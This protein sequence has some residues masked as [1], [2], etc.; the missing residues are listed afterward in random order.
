MKS[1][2]ALAGAL[3]IALGGTAS[4]QDAPP[5][6]A[7]PAEAAPTPAPAPA[8]TAPLGRQLSPEETAVL[9]EIEKDFSRWETAA[10]AHGKRVRHI[11]Y[12]EYEDRKL[13]LQRRYGEKITAADAEQRKRRLDAIALL[14]KFI[15]D[16]PSHPQFTPDAM[17]RLASLYLDKANDD[18]QQKFEAEAL[19]Q[20]GSDAPI[21]E[22]DDDSL[23]ADYTKS[24][25]LWTTIVR[26]FP[27]YR[28]RA[29][30]LHLLAYYLQQIGRER[31]GLQVARALVCGNKYKPLDPPPPAPSREAVRAAVAA[32]VKATFTD[33][34]DGCTAISED[35]GLVANTW[36]RIVGNIH[37]FTPGELN[38]AV[39]AYK[40]VA[41]DQKSDYF[42][43]A[44][45]M[46]AWSYYRNDDFIEGIR[47]FDTLV[48]V[49]DELVK[50]D[51]DPQ[52]R[53]ESLQYIAISFTDPWSVTEQPDP[54]RAFER[55][56]SFYKD[57]FN[58]PHVR[59]VFI[60]LGDTFE[61]IEAREQAIDA[62]RIVIEKWPLHPNTPII[63]Q[64]IVAMYEAM[65]DRDM[66]DE[67]A[68][69]LASR[70]APGSEW[71]KAN[72]TDR[73]AMET[74]ARISERMLQA[75]A[76]NTHR[77]AQQARQEYLANQTPEN[78]ARYIE[79]YD[80]AAEL[81]GIF[82]R[83]HPTAP[84]IYEFT[85]RLGE[86][87]FFAEKY[88]QAIEHYKWVR[89]HRELSQERFEAAA[90]S[91]VQTYAKF[92]EQE[93]AAG[94]LVDPPAPELSALKA[95]PKP[96]QPLP[97]P[98]VYQAYRSALDEYM[99]LVNDPKTA[100]DMGY[101]AAVISFKHLDL[102]DAEARFQATLDRHC[103]STEATKAKDG[104]LA[105]YE[106]LNQDDKFRATNEKFISKKCGSEEDMTLARAQNRSKE[107]REAEDLSAAS[108]FDQAAIAFY[109]YY[110]K[111]PAGDPNIPVALYNA[112]LNYDKSGK[113]KT[114]VYLYKEFLAQKDKA[115]TESEYYL[116][117]LYL[118]A[119]SYNNA[120]DY[121]N[122]VKTYLQVVKA[123][124]EKGR[125]PPEGVK[126][127]LQEMQVNAL[128]NA[129]LI[130]ELD[131]VFQD[132]KSDP[133]TGAI[134]L[135]R[136]YIKAETDRRK[137][138]RAQWAIARVY[139][140]AGDLKNLE[141]AYGEWRNEYKN[142]PGNADDYV[143]T[144]YNMAK[145]YE[146]KGKKR[147]AEEK[148]KATIAAWSAVGKPAGGAAGTM[149]AEFDFR[150]AE[151]FKL[152]FDKYKITKTPTTEKEAR[153]VLDTL[154]KLSKDTRDRYLS[155]SKYESGVWGLAALVRVGDV[156]FF[157]GLKIKETPPPKELVK[158]QNKHPDKDILVEWDASLDQ[159]TVPLVDQ[160]AK[161]W[162]KVLEAGK[163]QGVSNEWTRLAEERLHDFVDANQFPVLRQE[164]VEGT[165][166]P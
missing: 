21:E 123:A 54:A 146:K 1:T 130:R 74:Q 25:D 34:Y 11:L 152:K 82:V 17:F 142:D 60:Q 87:L 113:P 12:R 165:E 102:A 166:E 6:D 95:M 42:D 19:A 114:A 24:I 105:I 154:D 136:R 151:A 133:G 65:G 62:W 3:V 135:Y 45:Y 103:G 156:L 80:K 147:D 72:E 28:Q 81:Y 122:A 137:R 16:Y 92:V 104:L 131:R 96:I 124:G 39:S 93:I 111:A 159:L 163:T 118:T 126:L 50:K 121:E 155:L 128:F 115:F 158:L 57:R 14:E 31:E 40:R 98:A 35:K 157:H 2:R 49:S 67:E 58:E 46:L 71:Y 86:T 145:I 117:A 29:G 127:T 44:L 116:S 10:H 26:D 132:P 141:K 85:Y 143:F 100:P 22:G 64:K 101:K 144:F 148:R 140:S 66:A 30:T 108:K 9:E 18:F 53:P 134:S 48:K 23:R 153:K 4:A 70:Y 97:V 90:Y 32:N 73:E 8:S 36:V 68:G 52:L 139:E 129:A 61:I 99:R 77:A 161:Q 7:K 120:C 106:A 138:D 51:R 78:K 5:S 20:E 75:A 43:E 162:T 38:E 164:L 119:V 33:P 79:L 149:A 107:F 84:E 109:R 125:K 160:A 41:G 13:A 55:A 47:A 37:F 112:A 89:D 76:E 83:E 15:A 91:I 88:E 63:H 94:K 56:M 110:K 69:R 27:E 150:E 59:D